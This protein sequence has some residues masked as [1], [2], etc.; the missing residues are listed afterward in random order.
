MKTVTISSQDIVRQWYL[1]D[2]EDMVLG[3]LSTCIAHYLRGKHKASYSPHVDVG[4]SIVVINAEKVFLTGNKEQNK[5]YYRHTGYPG[6]IKQMT[7]RELLEKHPERV[8]KK[9][10]QGM[11]PRNSLGRSMLKKLK[12]YAGSGHPHEAQNLI[13]LPVNE[14]VKRINR[15][16]AS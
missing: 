11:L 8:L 2:A 16:A 3:R 12:I 5:I 14:N 7:A 15:H 6:G 10:V 9:A 4:D 1:V 13:P